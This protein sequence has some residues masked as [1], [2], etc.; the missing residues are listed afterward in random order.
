MYQNL[1]IKK[2]FEIC[3]KLLRLNILCKKLQIILNF[4][5]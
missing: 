2:R 4:N 1:K 5:I 3:H